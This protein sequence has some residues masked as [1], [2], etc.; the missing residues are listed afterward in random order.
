MPN[1]ATLALFLLYGTICT[2]QFLQPR[3]FL[4]RILELHEQ[5]NNV[6]TGGDSMKLNVDLSSAQAYPIRDDLFLRVFNKNNNVTLC[7]TKLFDHVGA[8]SFPCSFS[9]NDARLRNGAN[10]FALEVFSNTNWKVYTTQEIPDIHYFNAVAYEGHYDNFIQNSENGPYSKKIVVV[11]VIAAILALL[12]HTG[13]VLILEK[14]RHIAVDVIGVQTVA[15]S[16]ATGSFLSYAFTALSLGLS[17]AFVLSGVGLQFLYD[18]F[19]SG[20][21]S[22]YRMLLAALIYFKNSMSIGLQG[23]FGGLSGVFQFLFDIFSAGLASPF[24]MILAGLSSLFN[25]ISYGS[26]NGIKNIKIFAI[27]STVFLG[28][29]FSDFSLFFGTF[30]KS[31]PNDFNSGL[32]TFSV[33][34]YNFPKFS[35]M[36]L[37]ASGQFLFDIFYAGLSSP[38]GMIVSGMFVRTYILT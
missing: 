1:T 14:G 36:V 21:E 15:F 35:F 17:N 32:K 4:E 10:N 8:G 13:P 28:K 12:F 22:P 27:T 26:K 34:L 29:F 16:R 11:S 38:C 2:C 25:S 9:A 5:S 18:I 33:G 6:L 20:L 30:L 24:G 37:L 31:F 23:G 3:K 7:E 19:S